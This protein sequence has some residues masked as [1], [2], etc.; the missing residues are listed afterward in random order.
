MKY[1]SSQPTHKNLNSSWAVLIQSNSNP[2]IRGQDLH[3][4][5]QTWISMH[6]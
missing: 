2:A 1:E 4:F 3:Q 5:L 6:L